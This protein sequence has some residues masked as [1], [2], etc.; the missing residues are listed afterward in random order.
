MV[1]FGLVKKSILK[2][3]DIKQDVL[4]ADFD[5]G[6]ILKQINTTPVKYKEIPKHPEVK[7]DFALLLDQKATYRELHELAF[8]AERKYLKDMTLFDVY[9]GKN[10]PEGKK[11]YAVSFTLQDD[12]STL[13]EKQIEKIMSKLQNSYERNL[14]ASLR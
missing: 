5:W 1:S 12:K 3:F 13:T 8:S 2:H 7:R 9:E 11:S 14:G 6:S 10:L 4:F